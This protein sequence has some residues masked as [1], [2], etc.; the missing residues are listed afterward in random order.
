VISNASPADNHT[1]RT[2]FSDMHE[3]VILKAFSTIIHAP[4]APRNK[5]VLWH[6]SIVSWINCN[7]DDTTKGYPDPAACGGIFRDSN[8]A[9]VS[10]FA[11]NLNISTTFLAKLIEAM[12]AN[13]LVFFFLF[14]NDKFY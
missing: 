7:I 8:A 9:V 6:H 5:E 1:T 12:L 10:C 3:F 11:Q 2:F 4:N 13:A 14:L